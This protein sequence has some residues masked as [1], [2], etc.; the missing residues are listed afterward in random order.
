M[1]LH[2]A[3]PASIPG[4]MPIAGVTGSVIT[5][6]VSS[7]VSRP[8][9]LQS[10][11]SALF[12]KPVFKSKTEYFNTQKRVCVALS[13]EHLPYMNNTFSQKCLICNC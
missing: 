13:L 7:K 9:L 1:H 2:S 11:K 4:S 8:E 3:W 6:A 5:L 12:C 10:Y